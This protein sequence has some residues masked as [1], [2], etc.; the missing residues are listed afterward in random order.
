MNP[1]PDHE[2]VVGKDFRDFGDPESS[3]LTLKD[4]RADARRAEREA[5]SS[6]DPDSEPL[7]AALNQ[8]LAICDLAD[9][10]LREQSKDL[11]VACWYC[12]GLVRTAGFSGLAQGLDMLAR[13]VDTFWDE[14]LY[15]VAD[16][17]GVETRI[18]PLAGLIGRGVAG[19]LG[20]PVKLLSL[21]DRQDGHPA[22]L[23]LLE[24]A[25]AP[26][27]GEAPEARER[28]AEQIDAIIQGMV[29]SSPEFLREL[30]A[31][32]AAALAGLAQLMT[33][34]EARAEVGSFA[35]Q[36][37]Q[38]LN[39]IARLLDERVGRLFAVEAQEVAGEAPVAGPASA[40]SGG[41]RPQGREDALRTLAEIADFFERSEPQSLVA[42]SLREVVRRA[43]LS[44]QELVAE[45]LPEDMQ[46][47]EFL[48]RAGIRDVEI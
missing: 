13:L 32:V 16:E 30:R 17:D 46:R 33:I 3:Y 8:W 5:A 24:T 31:D 39:E 41:G 4:L 25:Q 9:R 37:S 44:V 35:S 48:M 23:W 43:R 6:G 47:R 14:G 29:R 12:E 26:V 22:A 45:L 2:L 7:T 21:T 34:L 20:Q 27:R 36:L 1:V 18:A 15:P 10:A 28:Q 42:V 19:S 11:E 38:P 40:S